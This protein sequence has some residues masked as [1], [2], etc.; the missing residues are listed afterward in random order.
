MNP[1]SVVSLGPGDPDLLTLGAWR[2][3]RRADCI[4]CPAVA[5]ASG[6]D[7]VSRAE[8]ILLQVGIDPHHIRRF[9]LPM[10]HDR[11]R[12]AA[13]Y[14]AVADEVQQLA[15]RQR[16]A[17]TAEG[18]A[19]IYSS[20]HYIA[21]RLAGRGVPLCY[22]AGVPSF[23]AAATGAGLHLIKGD[24][25]LAVLP[26]VADPEEPVRLLDAGWR[27]VVMKLPQNQEALRRVIAQR[28]DAEWHYFEQ[29]GTA[30]GCHLT[31][32]AEIAERPFPYFSL[33]AAKQ[34]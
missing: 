21:D 5:E 2:A 8:Q 18:D 6:G 32:P 22:L 27:V 30:A 7:P 16:V 4:F 9:T 31:D 33:L 28:P 14:D 23:V 34:A 20:V 17:V 3:L 25:P 19:G 1:V 11:S 10:S 29:V 13:A 24:E 15:R 12:A 26:R